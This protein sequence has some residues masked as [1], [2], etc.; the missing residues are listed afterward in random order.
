M[1]VSYVIAQ[2]AGFE[3][4]SYLWVRSAFGMIWIRI[5]DPISHGSWGIKGTAE[6]TLDKDSADSLMDHM[7]DPSDLGSQ[8]EMM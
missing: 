3:V 7:H 1:R 6:S 5:S 4:L 8:N 2:N